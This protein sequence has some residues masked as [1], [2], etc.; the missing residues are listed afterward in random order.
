GNDLGRLASGRVGPALVALPVREAQGRLDSMNNGAK[1]RWSIMDV[2]GRNTEKL[3]V[4]VM[5]ALVAL[6]SWPSRNTRLITA[7]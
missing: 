4:A 2:S 3:S 6:A 1:D 5:R 7:K